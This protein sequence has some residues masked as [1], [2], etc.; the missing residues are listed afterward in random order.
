M[1]RWP[2][3]AGGACAAPAPPTAAASPNG[4]VIEVCHCGGGR[5][6]GAPREVPQGGGARLG[7]RL[8]RPRRASAL[9]L[10]RAGGVPRPMPGGCSSRSASSTRTRTRRP[11]VI[12]PLPCSTGRT[13]SSTGAQEAPERVP[14][15]RTGSGLPAER[16]PVGPCPPRRSARS[17]SRQYPFTRGVRHDVPRRFWT[18]PSTRLST[19][20]SPT[21]ATATCGAGHHRLSVAFDLPTQIGYDSDDR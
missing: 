14:D 6:Q 20:R 2:A 19:A 17:A 8:L 15:F 1:E 12:K 5:S 9:R 7:T 11:V 13:R 3:S 16:V 21:S 10:R 18:M 4:P